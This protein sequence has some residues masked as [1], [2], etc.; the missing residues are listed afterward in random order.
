MGASSEGQPREHQAIPWFSCTRGTR[1]GAGL[2]EFREF[3]LEQ[4]AELV[5]SDVD[6]R[7]GPVVGHGILPHQ[8]NIRGE[9]LWR[10]VLALVHL[11]LGKQKVSQG[12]RER[13]AD[14]QHA[15]EGMRRSKPEVENT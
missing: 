6:V 4:L 15:I 3:P 1:R 7:V 14:E 10:R 9:L 2:L 5:C 8:S 11:R 12:M 13:C